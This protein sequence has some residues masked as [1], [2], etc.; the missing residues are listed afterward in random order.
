M[1]TGEPSSAATGR[2]RIIHDLREMQACVDLQR[3]VW[4]YSDQDL[5]PDHVFIVASKTGGAVLGAF[6]GDVL[7]GF[8]LGFAGLRKGK[9]YI[10]S[11]MLAVLPEHRK[12]GIGRALKLA[13][14]ADA[15]EKGIECIEW[16]FDPLQLNKAHFNITSLGA[17]ARRYLPNLY[18]R[19][20]SPLHRGLATDRLLAE[21]WISSPRVAQILEGVSPTL[22]DAIR[23]DVPADISNI[24]KSNP[25][26][27]ERIQADVRVEFQ[28]LI[29]EGNAATYFKL[30]SQAGHYVFESYED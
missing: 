25:D 10:H 8:V 14:T 21:W 18:G 13:Q 17:I 12:R 26:R 23:I 29:R 7:V 6:E 3:R 9:N 22:Q 2:V 24:A 5:V 15:L 19:T 11:H 1:S 4:S 30:D 27:A 20:S 16:T 28:R